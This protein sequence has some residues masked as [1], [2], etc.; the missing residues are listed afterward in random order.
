VW[1]VIGQLLWFWVLIAVLD[2]LSSLIGLVF[3]L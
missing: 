1:K 3:V 2:W